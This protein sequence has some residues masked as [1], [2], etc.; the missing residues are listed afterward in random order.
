MLRPYTD[1]VQGVADDDDPVHVI[2]HYD[3]RIQGDVGE[4]FWDLEPARPC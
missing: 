3:E 2:G 1:P 4:V